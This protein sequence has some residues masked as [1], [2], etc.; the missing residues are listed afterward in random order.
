[1]P[2]EV[3]TPLRAGPTGGC[4]LVGARTSGV[5]F[6]AAAAVAEEKASERDR[7]GVRYVLGNSCGYFQHGGRG[8]WLY[9]L[10]ERD[11][12]PILDVSVAL[13]I[14]HHWVDPLAK[15]PTRRLGRLLHQV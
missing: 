5:G 9:A 11:S 7:V 2:A 4:S 14:L 8:R 15:R 10:M 3:G 6:M 1:M 12:I 13:W